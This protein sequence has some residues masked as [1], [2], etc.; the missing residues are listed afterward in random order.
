MLRENAATRFKF[1]PT[2]FRLIPNNPDGGVTS[3]ARV[4]SDGP[5]PFDFSGAVSLAAV[6]VTL[7]LDNGAVLN[8]TLDLTTA[9][10]DEA[11]TAAELAT[12]WTAAS[13][14][15]WTGTVEAETG[16]FKVAKTT[17]GSA[18]YAQVGGELA[19][20]TGMRAT[21]IVSNNQKS[22][23][24]EAV[25][26]DSEIIETIDSNGLSTS[27][28]T[29]G[30]PT[31]ATITLTDAS[32]DQEIK[33]LIEGGTFVDDGFDAMVYESPGPA[34]VKPEFTIETINSMYAR[35][36]NQASSE[37]NY[38]WR[39]YKSCKGIVGGEA[40]DRNFQDQVYTI[41][42]VPYRDPLTGAKETKVYSEQILTVSEYEALHFDE[43]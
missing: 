4:V 37:A 43:L 35:D 15:G 9:V 17:P 28:N 3:P 29:D 5:G 12:A 11:V 42:A 34:S 40:G 26:K 16:Y 6:T 7:Q 24:V 20:Y 31:G 33:A 23:A 32:F 13:V 38:V 25:N 10:D 30:Y 36:A 8:E 27:I 19:T 14:S 18:R 1:G 21:I 41:T 39:R 22:I 2:I